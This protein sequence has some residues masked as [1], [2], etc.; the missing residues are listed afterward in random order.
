MGWPKKKNKPKN[1][2]TVPLMGILNGLL[3]PAEGWLFLSATGFSCQ[4]GPSSSLFACLTSLF[5]SSLL[6]LPPALLKSQPGALQDGGRWEVGGWRWEV[7]SG[8]WKGGGGRGEGA[9][10]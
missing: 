4:A 5:P 3:I 9:P 1:R 10:W 7:G 6:S 8:R 2:V